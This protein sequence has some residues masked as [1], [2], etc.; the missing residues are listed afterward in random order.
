[1]KSTRNTSVVTSDSNLAQFAK[2]C[3]CNIISSENFVKM[4][5]TSNRNDDEEQRIKEI[6]NQE[7]LKLFKAKK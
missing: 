4:I 2:V 5:R 1:M 7:I 6:S 3:G